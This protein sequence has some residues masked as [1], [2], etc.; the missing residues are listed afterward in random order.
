M[1][2]EI[3][4]NVGT[5]II[6]LQKP[7]IG[8]RELS[9][10]IF[11]LYWPQRDRTAIRI[12]TAVRRDLVN[13]IIVEHKTDLVNHPY[14]MLL[15]IRDL[16]LSKKPRKKTRVLNVYNNRVKQACIWTSNTS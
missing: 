4:L 8:N 1:A 15:E 10:S 7:F 16:N 6:I 9:H 3:A 2:L 11:N 14:F 5:G 13:K 12:M